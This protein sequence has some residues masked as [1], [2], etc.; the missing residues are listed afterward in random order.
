MSARGWALVCY[1][2]REDRRLRRVAKLLEGYGERI[3]YS[4]FRVRLSTTDEERLRWKLTQLTA[5]EDSWL[6]I[7]LCGTCSERIGRRDTRS[8]WG[9]EQPPGHVV[10]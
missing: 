5:P 8:V 7:R 1:D 10:L 4:V 3:Q 9:A 6:I 2:I